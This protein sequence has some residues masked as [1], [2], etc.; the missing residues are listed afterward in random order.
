M[1]ILL[2]IPFIALLAPRLDAC[3]CST[4]GTPCHAAG[5]AAAAFTGT[6]LDTTW[7][8]MQPFAVNNEPAA[9][10]RRLSATPDPTRPIPRALYVVRIQVAE[11]L[12]GIA[13]GQKEIEVVTGGG[14][15]DC[16]YPF[17]VGMDYVVYAFKNAEGRLETT[18]CSRTQ[19]LAQAAEDL[20][21]F[22]AM[23][24]APATGE[25]LIRTDYAGLPGKPGVSIVVDGQG[26]RR[27]A[28]T[29]GGGNARFTDLPP[30]EYSIH[31]EADGDLPDDPKVQLY[32]KGCRE[33]TLTRALRITGRIMT[34]QGEPA[35]RVEV[36]IRPTQSAGA[37]GAWTFMGVT[38][39]DGRYEINI[40]RP[41][42]YYLGINLN[43]TATT[44]APYPR[45]FYPGTEV[46]ALAFIIDFFGKPDSAT[47]NFTLPDR[48]N[49]RI[50]EGIVLT[51]DGHP[52]PRASVSV[53]DSF[54]AVIAI[55]VTD[56]SGRFLVRVF[57]QIPYRL[58]AVFAGDSPGTAVSG[59]PTDIQP[60][61]GPLSLRLILT[62]P[63]I[64]GR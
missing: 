18:I 40:I 15:G 37:Q 29:D 2:A 9:G 59:L 8:P 53:V 51:S 55:G 13:P 46:Q 4:P 33:L 23:A 63:G 22:R 54:N 45:W 47:Y 41:G 19:P 14:G 35:S 38:D 34:K 48:Q 6:V 24:G 20:R 3:S 27:T 32:A 43:N 12:S 49:P 61:T 26:S 60:G 44:G 21:Y 62:Q 31:E 11:V 5:I 58:Y 64:L 50:I 36:Q 56:D 1:R 25:L 57:A 30:G 17:Q 52:R 28:R 39:S 16:G 7:H 10:R 42:Q